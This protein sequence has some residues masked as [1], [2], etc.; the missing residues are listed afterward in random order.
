MA[1]WAVQDAKARFSEVLRAAA[2][3]PQ[4]ISYRGQDAAVLVSAEEFDRLI[5]KSKSGRQ[6]RSLADALRSCPRARD[7]ELPP[8]GFEPMRRIDFG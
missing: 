6:T 5:G 8:R 4:R 3:E 2:K 7:F 1:R